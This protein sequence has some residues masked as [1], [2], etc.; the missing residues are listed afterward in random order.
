MPPN[1]VIFLGDEGVGKTSIIRFKREAK[2]DVVM[3]PTIGTGSMVVNVP[4]S[5][6]PDPVEL[7]VWDT[8]GQEQYRSMM[9]SYIREATVVVLTASVIDRISI[10]SLIFSWPNAVAELIAEP[11][12]VVALNKVDLLA[13]DSPTGAELHAELSQRFSSVFLVS[14]KTGAGIDILFAAIAREAIDRSV[15]SVP[16]AALE[17]A[18]PQK[19]CC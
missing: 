4:L 7:F 1:K 14:A 12:F 16:T 11:N 3:D 18:P 10:D 17:P 15:V 19:G 13:D 2:F 8:A 9:P 6:S 5:G